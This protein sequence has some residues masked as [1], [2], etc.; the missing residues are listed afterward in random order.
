MKDKEHKHTVF[1]VEF[2]M[3]NAYCECGAWHRISVSQG[4]KGYE[5]ELNSISDWEFITNTENKK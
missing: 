5:W 1:R 4:E 3:C 2:T